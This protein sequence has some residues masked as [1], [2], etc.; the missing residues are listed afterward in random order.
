MNY[1]WKVIGSLNGTTSLIHLK[2]IILDLVLLRMNLFGGEMWLEAVIQPSLVYDAL[3]GP[4]RNDEV[5]WWK[6]L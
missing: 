5:W 1:I 4:R 3:F 6:K 2:G